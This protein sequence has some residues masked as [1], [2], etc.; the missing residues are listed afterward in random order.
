MIKIVGDCNFADG[1]FDTG[2]GIG[3]SLEDKQNPFEY[4]DI[5]DSDYWIGNFECVTSAIS[6]KSKIQSSYFR[7]LPKYLYHFKH[8]NLYGVA[9]NHVMQHGFL[10]YE[11]MLQTLE[12]LGV[13]YVGADKKRSHVLVHQGRKIGIIA[14]SQRLDNFTDAPL[15]WSNPEYGE[16]TKEIKSLQNMDYRIAFVHWGTEF[17][18][19]PYVDQ[20]QF[21]HFLIDCGIDLVI[22]MHPHVLQGMEIYKGKEIFYSLGN[23]VFNMEWEPTWYSIIVNVDFH[24]RQPVSFQYIKRNNINHFPEY[25]ESVPKQYTIPILSEK[26]NKNLENELYFMEVSNKTKLYRKDNRMAFIKNLYRLSIKDAF[27]IIQDFLQRKLT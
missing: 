23:C 8:L 3:S 12:A 6:N 14:F 16:I 4:L 24:S 21:A 1:Y 10:A 19:Y 11:E 17:I 20:K 26:I 18:D 27:Q 7:I 5:R 15:Y 13:D 25:V 2:F 9:N 22:G